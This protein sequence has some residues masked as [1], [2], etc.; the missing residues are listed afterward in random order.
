MKRYDWMKEVGL[1]RKPVA[2][3]PDGSWWLDI[4]GPAYSGDPVRNVLAIEAAQRDLR[5]LQVNWSTRK[6]RVRPF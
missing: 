2:V 4:T 3:G 5:L 6:A 1:S